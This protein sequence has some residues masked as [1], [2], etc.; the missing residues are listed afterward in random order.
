MFVNDITLTNFECKLTQ[1]Q[2]ISSPGS[3]SSALDTCKYWVSWRDSARDLPLS[4]VWHW[5]ARL[6]FCFGWLIDYLIR[7]C[8][9]DKWAVGPQQNAANFGRCHDLRS[10]SC[11]PL[12]IGRPTLIQHFLKIM[13][14]TAVCSRKKRNVYD[15]SKQEKIGRF[16]WENIRRREGSCLNCLLNIDRRSTWKYPVSY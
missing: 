12:S 3:E 9:W 6:R 1:L 5:P 7:R 10:L 11:F 8:L 14:Q 13:F 2:E 4:R 15:V 16:T